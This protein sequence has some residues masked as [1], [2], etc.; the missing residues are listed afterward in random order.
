MRA[1]AFATRCSLL[2]TRYY[3]LLAARY[4][5]FSRYSL[6]AHEA[7]SYGL[8]HWEAQRR[9][10]QSRDG[11]RGVTECLVPRASRP[12][13]VREVYVLWLHLHLL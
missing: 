12:P 4:S 7:L 11:A 1:H 6:F 2:A 5:L 9:T 8:E 13:M 10:E 3:L